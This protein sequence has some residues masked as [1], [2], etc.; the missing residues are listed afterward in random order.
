MGD[1]CFLGESIDYLCFVVSG[2]LEVAQDGEV[3][4]LLGVGDVFGDAFWRESTLGQSTANVR[5][6]TYCDIHM[7]KRE[8]LL[9]VLAF[10][11]NFGHAFARNIQLTYNLRQRVSFSYNIYCSGFKGTHIILLGSLT[12]SLVYGFC[13]RQFRFFFQIFTFCYPKT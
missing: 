7:I 8:C 9:D 10:Y 1:I 4:G 6:L 11:Q 12:D 3:T 13:E 5:A 2:S